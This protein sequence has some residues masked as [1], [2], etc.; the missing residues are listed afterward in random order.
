MTRAD[1]DMLD[2][3]ITAYYGRN[4]TG[5]PLHVFLDDGNCDRVTL[6][7]CKRNARESDDPVGE[8]IATMLLRAPDEVI[9]AC[10]DGWAYG[11]D[12]WLKVVTE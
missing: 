3:V 12:A 6:F 7:V 5:G 10:R 4:P 2:G 8:A 1:L 9:H 11:F